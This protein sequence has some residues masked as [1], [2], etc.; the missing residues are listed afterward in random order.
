MTYDV[1][2]VPEGEIMASVINGNQYDIREKVKKTTKHSTGS[3]ELL[4]SKKEPHSSG[5]YVAGRGA[6]KGKEAFR[7]IE[8]C[9]LKLARVARHCVR[10]RTLRA[11]PVG[12]TG[13]EN[14]LTLALF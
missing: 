5:Q 13:L 14:S 9:A 10:K 12:Q 1:Q 2:R 3:F 8:K 11:C 6:E 7:R 4:T